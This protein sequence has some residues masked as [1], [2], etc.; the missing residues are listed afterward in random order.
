MRLQQLRAKYAALVAKMQQLSE[1][2]GREAREM[3]ADER[4]SFATWDADAEQAKADIA[5]EEKLQTRLR[6]V[7][8]GAPTGDANAAVAE[9]E[10]RAASI[11]VGKDRSEDD[12]KKGFRSHRE[13]LSAV[14]A[15]G[16]GRPMDQKLKP[17]FQ[18]AAGS[19]EHGGYDAARGGFLVPEAFSPSLLQLQPEDDPIAG[20]TTPFPMASPVVKIAARVD[21]NHTSSV[22]GGL[23]VTR[24]PETVSA[25]S[26]RMEFEQIAMNATGLFGLAFATEEVMQDSP[27]SFVALIAAGFSQEFGAKG[28][29]ERLNGSGV[30]EPEG[31]LNSPALISVAKEAGQAADTINYDNVKKMRSRVWGYGRSI[32]MANH[33]TMPDLMSLVQVVGTGGAPVYQPSAQEDHPDLLLGRPIFYTEYCK[34]IGDV[35]DLVCANFSQYLDGTYQPLQSAESMHVRFV[36]HER[37]FKFWLRNDGR[38]WWR[39]ALTPKNSTKTLSPFVA[40]AAR[41]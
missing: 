35:G 18:A 37:A 30:G 36:E 27:I 41:A 19:D 32:W 29:D 24:R 9:R 21:K 1:Q 11:L 5:S 16:Q 4:A 8:A 33:D 31:I 12:P 2:I 40:L 17:L 7:P 39:S 25:T 34:T 6:D 20:R 14:M 15:H 13:F 22:S 38:G 23:T 3:T 28:V 10:A 26:S